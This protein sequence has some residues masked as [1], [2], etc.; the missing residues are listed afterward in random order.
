METPKNLDELSNRDSPIHIHEK[1][2][3]R[4]SQINLLNVEIEIKNIKDETLHLCNYCKDECA[5]SIDKKHCIYCKNR[6]SEYRKTN[7]IFI[8]GWIVGSIISSLAFSINS[9]LS[10][11]TGISLGTILHSL[12][13]LKLFYK[14]N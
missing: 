3:E 5:I 7:T 9:F 2:N 1:L 6:L 14:L 11:G 4:E 12:Y 10:I 13:K 8:S